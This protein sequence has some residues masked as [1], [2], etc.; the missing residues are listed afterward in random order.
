MRASGRDKIKKQQNHFK[1][2]RLWLPVFSEA[3]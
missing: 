3:Y 1:Q 2:L